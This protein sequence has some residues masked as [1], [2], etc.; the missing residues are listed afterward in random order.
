M[1][2]RLYHATAVLAI[3]HLLA[4]GGL[5]G[6]LYNAGRLDA[7][8]VDTLT[9]LLRGAPDEAAPDEQPA[10]EAAAAEP[11][12]DGQ[13]V[14]ALRDQRRRNQLRVAAQVRA[15]ADLQSQQDLLNQLILDLVDRREKFDDAIARWERRKQE[16]ADELH[17]AG[18]RKQVELVSKLP[19]KAAKDVLIRKY[20]ESPPDAVRLL[21][22][23]RTTTSKAVLEQMK[24]PEEAQVRFELLELLAE[25][26]IDRLVPGAGTAP[27]NAS[28]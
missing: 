2:G 7:E 20:K 3:A 14:E 28:P 27:T 4:L 19:A 15:A 9:Q 26:D 21:N 1:L 10:E 6:W 22:A 13:S 12:A 8:T 5:L 24:T 23:L 17:D 25:Q 11:L 16:Q 18:F